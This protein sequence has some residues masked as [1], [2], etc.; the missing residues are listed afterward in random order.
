MLPLY[1]PGD[2]VLTFNWHKIRKNDVVVFQATSLSH[3]IKRV[4]K[5]DAKFVYVSGDNKNESAK[6]E[7]IERSRIVGRV[8]LKY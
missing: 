4:D 8:I 1:K 2:H 3:Y 7:P 5:I 6:I